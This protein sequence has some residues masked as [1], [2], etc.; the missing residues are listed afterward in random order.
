MNTRRLG[1]AFTL[2][3]L[4]VVIG[5]I[6]ALLAML[7]P[8]LSRAR[9]QSRL[10][11]D[12]ASIRQCAH[13][14]IGMYAND[15]K[16]TLMPLIG[17]RLQPMSV[18]ELP[19]I[20]YDPNNGS[21]GYGSTP[22]YNLLWFDFLQ[23]YLAPKNQRDNPTFTGVYSPVLYCASD[24]MMTGFTRFG[25]SG[26]AIREPSWR[27]NAAI[28]K[29]KAN[30]LPFQ[31]FPERYWQ[32]GSIKR[33]SEKV[34]FVEH[35]YEGSNGAAWGMLN[36]QSWFTEPPYANGGVLNA[37]AYVVY[38][39]SGHVSTPRHPKHFVAAFCDGSARMIPFTERESL[40]NNP[41]NGNRARDGLGPNWD[42]SR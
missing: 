41:L 34:L 31:A 8:A 32:V 17:T 15:Y 39:P 10:V 9:E 5:I 4:L 2:V 14:A 7:L 40:V 37:N 27:M 35:H 24:T 1:R 19:Y 30:G 33:S 38:A 12:L 23:T 42:L 26:T 28:T 16:G 6:A 18:P 21:I 13:V 3:E 22:S 25:W 36:A 11:Q 20:V 29:C